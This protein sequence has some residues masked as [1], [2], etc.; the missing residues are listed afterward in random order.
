MHRLRHLSAALAIAL[1]TSATAHAG[2]TDFNQMVVIGDSLSDNGNISLSQGASQPSRFTTNPGE[3][4]LEHVADHFG[5][6]LTP[7]VTGG[8]DYAFGG[9]RVAAGTIPSLTKQWATYVG[10][11]G[12]HADA[13]TLYSVWGGANDI[14]YHVKAV[15][16]AAKAQQ[17]IKQTVQAKVTA[18]VT[19]GSIPP[20]QAGAYAQQ[21][22]PAVTQQVLAQFAAAGITPETPAQVQ[23][24]VAKAAQQELALLGQM[25]SKGAEYVLVFNLPDIGKTPAAAAQGKV[26]QQSLAQLS[27]LYNGVLA[28]GLNP[29]SDRGLNIVP[30][31]VYGLFNEVIANPSAFGFTN[32]TAPACGA[33]SSS[34][35]CGPQGSG[36]PYTY[37]PGTDQSYLFADGVH[38]TTAAHKMLGQYVIAELSAPGQVS[39]LAESPLTAARAHLNIIRDQMRIDQAGG[40]TRVF[41]GVSYSRQRFDAT[42]NSPKTDSNNVNLTIGL[43]AAAGDHF[44]AGAALGLARNDAD[45]GG[46]HGGYRMDSIIGTGYAVWHRGGGYIG[47]NVGFAQLSY[48]DINRRFHLGALARTETG[49]T[50]GSQLMAGLNGGW[51][52]GSESVRTGPFARIQWQRVRVD[53]YSEMGDDSSAMWFGGQERVALVGTLGWQLKGNW[54]LGTSTLHPYLNVAW[55]HDD[56]ADPRQVRAGLSGMPG[57]FALTGFIADA[58]WAS[59]DLGLAADFSDSLSGWIG[60]HGRFADSNQRVNSLDLGMKLVF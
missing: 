32:V 35:K 59:A 48:N 52:F 34:V 24:G 40:N 19:G 31:N 54:K 56:R 9:A 10:N 26:A 38:P 3:V 25:H 27:L 14:F 44:N 17:L 23:A 5:F 47:A 43:D 29:L 58:D 13:H 18:A 6:N 49:Q 12:G 55:N 36:A 41:A 28:G 22:T 8:N 53:G 7:S 16:A 37:A 42:G 33:G 15:G 46:G 2:T 30:V 60:Y 20:A 11:N 4:A 57:S 51:W 1:A 45:I 21:I 50:S 39:M